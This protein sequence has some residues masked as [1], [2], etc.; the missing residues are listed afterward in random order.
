MRS[1]LWMGIGLAAGLLLGLVAAATQS[2]LLLGLARGLRPVGTLFLNL[3]SMVVIPLVATALFSGI[4]KLGHLRAVGRLVV[5]TLAFFWGT[6]VVGILIGFVV[7]SLVL[8]LGRLT[9]EQQAV[10]RQAAVADSSFIRKAAEDIPTGARFI[11]EL[12]PANPVKAAVDFNLLPVIVFVTFLAIAAASLPADKRAALTDLADGATDALVKIVHWVLLLAPIGIFALVA[13]I[14]A[15]FGWSLVHAMGWFI[16][17]V[18]L[19]LLIFIG[20]VYIPAV[21]VMGRMEPGRFLRAAFPSMMM[22]FSTTSSLATLPTMLQA[23]D[24]DLHLPRA[25]AGFALPLGASVNRG[26]SALFQAV[27]VLFIAQLYGIPLGFGELFQAGAAV[28]LASLTVASVPAASVV[29]LMP[30]FT[31]TGLPL[32]GLSILIGL[33]RIP[34]MF[35][36]MTNVTGHLTGA[37]VIAAIEG[38]KLE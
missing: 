2:E 26:G 32:Q 35:R 29:S 7:A 11:V 3:L 25:I 24:H 19:G 38:E 23:A 28:F 6:A 10:L 27:A 1:H 30:A 15:Q 20:A 14:V 21:A 13:P 9:S 16:V 5:R 22:G 31:A 18:I 4:A 37:A 12:I 17:A 33:D 34:D 8:P 36:T